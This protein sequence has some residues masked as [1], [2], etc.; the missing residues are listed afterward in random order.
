M[1]FDELSFHDSQILEVKEN[2]LD[3]TIDFFLEFP[4]DW[5][6]NKFEKRALSFKDV[7]VYIKKEIPFL[8]RPSILEIKVRDGNKHSYIGPSGIVTTSKFKI[9]M[10]TNAGSRFIEFSNVELLST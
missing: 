2:T 7:V 10:I 8:G 1:L 5:E 6:N 4:V 9:E 3:Q